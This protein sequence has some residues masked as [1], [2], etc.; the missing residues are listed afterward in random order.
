[1][2]GAVL[3]AGD[4]DPGDPVVGDR[5]FLVIGLAQHRVHPLEHALG[6][7]RGA[8]EPG[9]RGDHEDRRVDD[10]LAD[11]GPLVALALVGGDPRLQLVV[12]GAQAR[13]LDLVL[14]QRLGEHIGE[15]LR[16][17]LFQARFQRAVD[18]QG[19]HRR[20]LRRSAGS[21]GWR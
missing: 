16:V 14:G 17:R 5:S 7:A 21:P 3:V 10:P 12:D 13:H 18:D 8:A 2:V 20:R 1:V 6:D 4:E 19:L 11:S 9:R 15:R